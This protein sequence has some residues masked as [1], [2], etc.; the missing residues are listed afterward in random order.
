MFASVDLVFDFCTLITPLCL[1]SFVMN[2]SDLGH[3]ELAPVIASHW[4]RG[5][6]APR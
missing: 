3:I 5:G 6:S 1:I 4:D 2:Y